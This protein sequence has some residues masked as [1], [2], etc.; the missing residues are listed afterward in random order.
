MHLRGL[1]AVITGAAG[2]L[3]TALVN[4]F[5]DADCR[6]VLMVDLDPD[7]LEAARS[8]F[9]ADRVLAMVGDVGD[10]D[11]MDGVVQHAESEFG[12]VDIMVNNAGVISPNARLHHSETA[13]WE[14]SLRVNVIGTLNGTKAALRVMRPR[15]SGSIINTG[16]VAGV[17]AWTHS[18]P[19]CVSK[20]AVIH[21]TKVA[22]LEYAD[23]G[24]RVNCVCPGSFESGMFA[25][26]PRAAI[27][28]IDAR[29]PLGLGSADDVV[30]AYV[31]L[32]ADAS[33]W[34]TGAVLMVDGGYSVP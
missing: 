29:H 32:A 16:S 1:T 14:R 10:T 20:A 19:Y 3:G 27:D 30:G 17:T 11:A 34:T 22:A 8:Q 13:A 25:S 4:S 12:Q 21:M 33:R 6:A 9:P 15:R 18:G 5:L 28:A 7:A 31:Y 2:T 23:D 24:V 26:V